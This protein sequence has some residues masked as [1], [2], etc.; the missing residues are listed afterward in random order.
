MELRKIV[1]FLIDRKI[2]G[3]FP[4]SSCDDCPNMNIAEQR[5]L[6]QPGFL[7]YA[8]C[9]GNLNRNC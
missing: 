3:M 1:N 5:F 7:I 9:E 4:K 8:G 6:N 2:I